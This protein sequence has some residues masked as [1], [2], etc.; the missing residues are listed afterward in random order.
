VAQC[1]GLQIP[2]TVS[3][4]LTPTSTN[5]SEHWYAAGFYKP[6]RVVRWAATIEFESLRYYQIYKETAMKSIVFENPRT[7][8]RVVC[9]DVRNV[10]VIEGEEY[11]AVHRED[12]PRVFLIKK[13]A[14]VR[15][16]NP[17]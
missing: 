12:N 10:S 11:L 5:S 1:K 4:N 16:K 9:D 15:V 14:L 6:G 3:S 13:N 8:E 2:K 17:S 7:R